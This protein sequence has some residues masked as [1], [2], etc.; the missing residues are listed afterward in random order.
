[1]KL[2]ITGAACLLAALH[3]HAQYN[4]IVNGKM[5]GLK[6]EKKIILSYRE[7]GKYINDTVITNKGNFHFQPV[8]SQQPIRATL[9]MLPLTPDPKV[10]MQ[11]RMLRSD[12]QSFYLEAGTVTVQGKG[13]MEKA[14]IKGGV[15]QKENL[16]LTKLLQK[17]IEAFAPVK[18][19]VISMMIK[20]EG[21]GLDTSARFNELRKTAEEMGKQREDKKT[22]FITSHPDSYV[23]L[24]LVKDRA[25]VIDPVTFE[26]LFNILSERIKK[27][28]DGQA[29][30]DRLKKVSETMTGYA[31]KD[32]SMADSSGK[33]I[34]L[35]SFKGKYVL[36]DFWASWCGPCRAENPHVLKAYTRFKAKNFDILAVSIDESRRNWLKA[37][38]EDRL[39]W[40]QV[41]D[42]LGSASKA[43]ALYGITAI[44]QNFLIDPSGMIIARNLRGAELE[45]TLEK[46]LPVE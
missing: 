8:I 28:K 39:P 20:S 44:P 5:K 22:A 38:N 13:S 37:V 14:M 19:E 15:T 4:V 36:L 46:Y 45:K 32:F 41:S 30:G 6:H 42:L 12:A 24:D 31:A 21:R 17:D 11:E 26:P 1:M 40:T 10:S 18:E 9:T 3:L 29:L 43:A 2:L 33:E 34:S 23:S 25:A 7:N 35:S 16:E 27:S